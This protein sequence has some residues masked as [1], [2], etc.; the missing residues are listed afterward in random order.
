VLEALDGGAGG[1]PVEGRLVA[2]AVE[3]EGGEPP[4]QVVDGLALVALPQG[5]GVT[6]GY[7]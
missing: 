1:P 4:A 5:E 7:R 2:V 6:P 3:A